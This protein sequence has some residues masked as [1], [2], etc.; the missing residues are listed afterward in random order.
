VFERSS[1]STLLSIPERCPICRA[2]EQ[3]AA[4]ELGNYCSQTGIDRFFFWSIVKFVWFLLLS[5]VE[6]Q[7]DADGIHGVSC[8]SRGSSAAFVVSYPLVLMATFAALN[9]TSSSATGSV[10]TPPA[11]LRVWFGFVL[12]VH[13]QGF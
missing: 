5:F 12:G 8:G 4:T 2:H 3:I 6:L 1:L 11:F 13:R 10:Q 9:V 7:W